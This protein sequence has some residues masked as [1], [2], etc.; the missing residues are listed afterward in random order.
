MALG[1]IILLFSPPI[2]L[3]VC[4]ACAISGA[5]QALIQ[6]LMLVF[7]ADT[8]D[9]GQWKLKERYDSAVFSIQPF[10][11]KLGG[12]ISSWVVGRVVVSIGLSSMVPGNVTTGV[13]WILKLVMFM[14]PL[15]CVLGGYLL[16]R[17][18]YKIDSAFYEQMKNDIEMRQT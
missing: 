7:L 18:T 10:T 5:G 14:V 11:N 9:Y 3:P 17:K 8:V 13:I 1:Y 4:I 16:H 2:L 6:L 12:A 15:L